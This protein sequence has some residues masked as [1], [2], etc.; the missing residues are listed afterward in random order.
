[1][2]DG[3]AKKLKN[4]EMFLWNGIHSIKGDI[5]QLKNTIIPLHIILIT[6]HMMSILRILHKIQLSPITCLG[7]SMGHT[8]MFQLS[9]GRGAR[10]METISES[11]EQGR[12]GSV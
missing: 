8:I 3:W 6:H 1:M 12:P 2:E 11:F 7:G 9:P 5:P 4:K 10:K